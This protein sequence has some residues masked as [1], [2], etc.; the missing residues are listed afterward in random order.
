MKHNK[1]SADL[2]AK[3]LAL[4]KSDGPIRAI[5]LAVRL[6]IEGNRENKRRHIR[7][8]VQHLRNDCGE[9]IAADL[10]YG[11]YIAPTKEIWQMYLDGRQI[12]AKKIL[13]ITHKQL[14]MVQ[15]S[16]GQGLLFLPGKGTLNNNQFARSA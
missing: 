4:I 3:C 2:A 12:D 1:F 6:G 5:A 8:I 9:L 16:K 7:A 14:R 10:I 15:D 11:Y 13:G